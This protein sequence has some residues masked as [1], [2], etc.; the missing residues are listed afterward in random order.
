[1]PQF[2]VLLRGVNVGKGNR[3]PMAEFRALLETQGFAEVKT[4][5]NSGNAVFRCAAR[6]AA[7]SHAKAIAA[8]L[9]ER[10]GVGVLVVVKSS[11][12]FL[13]AVAE[14]PFSLLE[15][16]HSRFLVAFGQTEAAT[17]GLSALQPMLQPPESFHIG[18]HA[19][20]LH[21]AG[22]ILESKAG[23]A[24]LGK[25]GREVTTRNWATVLKLKALLGRGPA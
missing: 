23:S 18:H 8:R 6:S 9:Q 15:N 24:L 13:A 17:Q 3:V 22:G 4:L 20:Y 10:L 14:D 19:A 11:A 16:D 25:L 1:M 5:L 7:A 2:V 12:E 21:C